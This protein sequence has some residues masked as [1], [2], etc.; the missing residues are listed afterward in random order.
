MLRMLAFCLSEKVEDVEGEKGRGR[1]RE[2][3]YIP[4]KPPYDC[5]QKG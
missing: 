3:I 2:D 4:I 1:G 5:W